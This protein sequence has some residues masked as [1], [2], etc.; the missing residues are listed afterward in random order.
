M[1]RIENSGR[2]NLYLSIGLFSS[3][4]VVILLTSL[5]IVSMAIGIQFSIMLLI[6]SGFIFAFWYFCSIE[7]KCEKIFLN[8]SKESDCY[9]YK[10]LDEFSFA[11][12]RLS[13]RLCDQGIRDYLEIYLKRA[14]QKREILAR[15]DKILKEGNRG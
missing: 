7:A 14:K 9:N 2:N 5:G 1:E 8:S 6:A 4:I 13:G 12:Y 15:L 3:C 10:L 11:I